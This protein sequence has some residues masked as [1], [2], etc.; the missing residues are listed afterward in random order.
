LNRFVG[1]LSLAMLL[2]GCVAS[3]HIP[4]HQNNAP[5]FESIRW[6]KFENHVQQKYLRAVDIRDLRSACTTFLTTQAAGKENDPVD[7][8]IEAALKTLDRE[9]TYVA[10]T[11]FADQLVV[12]PFV[13]IGAELAPARPGNKG[14][15]VVAPIPGGPAERGGIQP[16][17]QILEINGKELSELH[18]DDAVRS[19]RGPVGSSLVLTLQRQ[20]QTAPLK[21]SFTREAIKIPRVR[22]KQLASNLA[23]VR[24]SVFT[25]DVEAEFLDRLNRVADS[26]TAGL[27]IDV[28]ASPGGS[29]DSFVKIASLFCEPGTP[30]LKTISR[31]ES[32][33]IFSTQTDSPGWLRTVPLVV[34][35]DR[36]TGGGA[37]ALAQIL[38]ER[39]QA[40]LIGETTFGSAL[41][42]TVFDLGDTAAVKLATARLESALGVNWLKTGLQVDIQSNNVTRIEF[43]VPGDALIDEGVRALMQYRTLLPR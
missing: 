8:C 26:S 35:V 2:V 34:L 29:F 6:R 43:G 13:G 31:H 39:R 4:T 36:T 33:E 7:L 37:E 19:L 27:V 16:G 38:R 12:P 28:R 42:T 14:L 11:A 22:T 40:K 17:D 23:W 10:P 20:G 32:K 3:P 25:K 15:A 5:V 1:A 41:M 24:V 21:M 30:L 9:S 18:I